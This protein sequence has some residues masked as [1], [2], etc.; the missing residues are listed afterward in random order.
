MANNRLFI[1]DVREKRFLYLC[2]SY[3]DWQISLEKME[4]M[5]SFIE[6]MEGEGYGSKTALAF[7]TEQDKLYDIVFMKE[8]GRWEDYGMDMLKKSSKRKQ[9]EQ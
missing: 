2:K 3:S 5:C 8:K 1:A 7:F 4:M 9:E 6:G